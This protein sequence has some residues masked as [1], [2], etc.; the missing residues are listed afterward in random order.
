MARRL[1]RLD[2]C[3]RHIVGLAVR[4]RQKRA[5]L[6]LL[7]RYFSPRGF[8]LLGPVGREGQGGAGCGP[9]IPVQQPSS[10]ARCCAAAVCAS[11]V[12]GATMSRSLPMPWRLVRYW[13]LP[14]GQHRGPTGLRR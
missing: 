3:H 5:T 7:R 4:R 13:P 11:L 10:F 8:N 12:D 2:V 6:L 1:D 14:F 9:A